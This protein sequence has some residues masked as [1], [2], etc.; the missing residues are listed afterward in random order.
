LERT[1]ISCTRCGCTVNDASLWC[2]NCH[3]DPE[4]NPTLKEVHD[5]TTTV[6]QIRVAFNGVGLGNGFTINEA[7]REGVFDT[8]FPQLTVRGMDLER[9]WVDV[10]NW[11]CEKLFSALYAFDAEGWKFYLPAFMCWTLHNWRRSSSPT[12]EWLI[13]SLTHR[14]GF[15]N[16][17]STLTVTQ[18]KAVLS[19]LS[20]CKFY[21]DEEAAAYAIKSYWSQFE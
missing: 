3:Q 20:F 13:G 15:A 8:E 11:K 7:N 2:D 16:R 4:G 21:V 5:A 12:P 1:Q 14:D 10:P 17:F 19:F 18:A 6:D 9:N